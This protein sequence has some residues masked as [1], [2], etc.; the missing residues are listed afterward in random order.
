VRVGSYV[1]QKTEEEVVVSCGSD[2]ADS[3]CVDSGGGS[4]W[5]GAIQW[6]VVNARVVYRVEK[7]VLTVPYLF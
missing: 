3:G 7:L 6:I 5:G 1:C 2:C 4:G